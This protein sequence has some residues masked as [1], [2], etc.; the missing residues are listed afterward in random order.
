ML[1]H[2]R[3]SSSRGA[4][5]FFINVLTMAMGSINDA[6]LRFNALLFENLRGPIPILSQR[7][8]KF[9]QD[10]IIGQ[11]HNVLGSADILGNPVGLFNSFTSG[12]QDIFY[13]PY[14]GFVMSDRPQDV[15][16]GLAKGTAS[17]VKK[18]VFGVSDSVAK[19]TSS[20]SK[21]CVLSS[22]SNPGL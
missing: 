11:V 2:D 3:A 22:Q 8:Q 17:F 4:I 21:G 1:M 6:P 16:I 14:N 18:T 20:I 10:Q 5:A 15:G 7:I 13:E 19:V 12:V 9:Y